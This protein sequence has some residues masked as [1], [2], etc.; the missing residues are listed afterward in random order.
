MEG[1]TKVRN[2]YFPY[3]LTSDVKVQQPTEMMEVIRLN[4]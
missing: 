2:K 3:D 4:D 1:K